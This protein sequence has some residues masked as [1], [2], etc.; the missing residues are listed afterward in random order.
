MVLP[1]SSDVEI[2]GKISV[3]FLSQ[4]QEQGESIKSK[5]L[6]AQTRDVSVV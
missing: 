1:G 6:E 4:L 5:I 3:R 2:E